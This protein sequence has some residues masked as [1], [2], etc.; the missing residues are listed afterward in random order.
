M[1][2]NNIYTDSRGGYLIPIEF[3]KL[4]FIPQ[5]VFA[6]SDVPKGHI[7]GEHAH[8]ITEQ[9]LLCVKGLITVYL[10]YGTHQTEDILSA[11]DSIYIPSM[12]WDS[13]KFLTG[14]DYMLVLASTNYDLND[15]ILDK[16]QFY[17]LTNDT[18]L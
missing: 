8:Y 17:R 16:T 4:T 5:R 7:R 11:G 3:D 12:V 1:N 2:T 10:D 13:Q 18:K 15:Y 6:V 14:N 9:L